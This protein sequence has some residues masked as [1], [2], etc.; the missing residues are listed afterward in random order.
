MNSLFQTTKNVLF[1]Q[2]MAR[3]RRTQKFHSFL[4]GKPRTD[5]KKYCFLFLS[6]LLC[7]RMVD[8]R[9]SQK[10]CGFSGICFH[11]KTPETITSKS[12]FANC[13]VFSIFVGV[14]LPSIYLFASQKGQSVANA[15]PDNMMVVKRRKFL[16]FR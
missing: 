10:S 4:Y 13:S 14:S 7:M 3:Y 9:G 15:F 1:S 2:R 16:F 5:H 11:G 6:I 12:D 8:D